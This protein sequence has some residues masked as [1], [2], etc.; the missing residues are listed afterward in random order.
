MKKIIRIFK[1]GN[2]CSYIDITGYKPDPDH[3]R[4][5]YNDARLI[6]VYDFDINRYIPSYLIRV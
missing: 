6:G 2:R 4:H 1:V 3:S 5:R